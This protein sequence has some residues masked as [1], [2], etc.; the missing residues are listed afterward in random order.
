MATTKKTRDAAAALA[1]SVNSKPL[2]KTGDKLLDSWMEATNP[3]QGLSI[4]SA[5]GIFDCARR[6]DTR[7][8]HWLYNE[9]EA[10]MPVLM[11]CA[12]RRSAALAN[13]DWQIRTRKPTRAKGYDENLA[14]EQAALL[15]QAF[16]DADQTNLGDAIEHLSQ[17][18]FRGFAH[19]APLW[20]ED[21][22]GI[23]GFDLLPGW[24]FSR[25]G[26]FWMWH[27]NDTA[28]AEPIPQGELCTLT[29]PR[30]IDY[31]AMAI[32]LRMGLGESK[33]G[34]FIE[35]Y[36]IP[37]VIIIMPQ[38][39]D[40][41]LVSQYRASAER[42]ANGGTGALPFGSIVNYAEGSRGVD[43]FTSFLQHQNEML[44][45][46]ST[47]GMLTSLTGATGLGDG[48]SNA[49]E[50]TWESIV[51]RDAVVVGDALNRGVANPILDAAFPGKPHLAQFILERAEAPT[52][53]EVFDAAGKAKLA[54]YT[55]DQAQLQE[56]SGYKLER[57]EAPMASGLSTGA[58]SE[59]PAAPAQ[60]AAVQETALNGAQIASIVQVV[61]AAAKREIPE[62]SV[63]PMLRVSFP[64]MRAEVLKAIVDSLA[65]FVPTAE[66]GATRVANSEDGPVE[67]QNDGGS[68][69]I[70]PARRGKPREKR[71]GASDA[72]AEGAEAG[73]LSERILEDLAEQLA[74]TMAEAIAK[75]A[76]TE[77]K[78]GDQA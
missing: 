75:A 27:R 55:V 8:L 45:L 63:M 36:G 51:G 33:W 46:M 18:F 34:Q 57:S 72:A 22:K 5:Q 2:T 52:A 60:D 65:G 3:L 32:C 35:R 54:G 66:T 77:E 38:D 29:R 62:A 12:E 61:S 70:A 74:G 11:V 14:K 47:G 56:R 67:I 40:P 1:V 4:S 42:V 7:R 78:T 26:R 16:G 10:A 28:T 73:T 39:I 20:D 6:G 48:T 44:V 43:P 59:T 24:A 25:S 9:M 58:A 31:P 30:H 53:A 68:G 13:I 17:A 37:P 41:A 19:V 50:A 15:E 69:R 76:A 71:S 21:R 23:K 64:A 49:H